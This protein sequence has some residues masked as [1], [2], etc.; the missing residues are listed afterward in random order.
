MITLSVIS[1]LGL[2]LVLLLACAMLILFS[3]IDRR[4]LMRMMRVFVYYLGSMAL[5]GVYVWGILALDRW[6]V[7]LLGALLM[8]VAT[9]YL[10]LLKARVDSRLFFLPVLCAQ[11]LGMATMVGSMLLLLKTTPVMLITAVVAIASGQMMMSS[12]AAL[13]TYVSSLW[14]TREHYLYLFSNGATHLE[15]VLPSVRRSLRASVIPLLQRFTSPVFVAPPLLFCGLLLAGMP[16]LESALLT[17]L[18][19]VVVMSANF[20]VAVLILLFA[21]R[22]VFDRSGKILL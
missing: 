17:V 21:D 10:T 12:S 6:W 1:S 11:L 8:T 18:L 7:A 16:P 4:L 19:S 13:R 14:H 15:A 20:F 3:V 5:V 9:S 22:R 2:A